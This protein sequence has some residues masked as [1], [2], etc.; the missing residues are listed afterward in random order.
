MNTDT[1]LMTSADL[2]DCELC[3]K[4]FDSGDYC[5]TIHNHCLGDDIVCCRCWCAANPKFHC[6]D[7]WRYLEEEEEEESSDDESDE[8]WQKDI[9]GCGCL[10]TKSTCKQYK[11][12]QLQKVEEKLKAL[13]ETKD[14]K[15]KD[16]I[17]KL[18]NKRN[19]L[20]QQV[21]QTNMENDELYAAIYKQI[22]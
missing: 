7:A 11:N 22:E 6:P 3:K 19:E 8:E 4:E 20:Q 13:C 15:H 21:H 1:E 12:I 10:T 18:Y 5:K 17:I 16:E 2:G 14:M 9:C